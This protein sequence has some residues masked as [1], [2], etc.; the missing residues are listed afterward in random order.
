MKVI[1]L[2]YEK[3]KKLN[4]STIKK[5]RIKNIIKLKIQLKT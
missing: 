1:G 3:R 2:L 4:N 5:K